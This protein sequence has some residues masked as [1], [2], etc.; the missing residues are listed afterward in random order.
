VDRFLDLA[1][2]EAKTSTKAKERE[3]TNLFVDEHEGEKGVIGFDEFFQNIRK[4]NP[5]C[6]YSERMVRRLNKLT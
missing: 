5:R 1:I 3:L 4:I 2:S 6:E